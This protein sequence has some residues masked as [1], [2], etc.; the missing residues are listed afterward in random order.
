MKP[1]RVVRT[2]EDV[3]STNNASLVVDGI[4]MQISRLYVERFQAL[5]FGDA[6]AFHAVDDKIAFLKSKLIAL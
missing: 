1:Q 4:L 5:R 2:G 3:G 6:Q